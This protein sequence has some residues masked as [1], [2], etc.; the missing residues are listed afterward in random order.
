M[1]FLFERAYLHGQSYSLYSGDS[2]HPGSFHVGSQGGVLTG[3]SGE[4]KFVANSCPSPLHI[5]FVFGH[6]LNMTGKLGHHLS[7]YSFGFTNAL[8]QP[9]S[10]DVFPEVYR[11]KPKQERHRRNKLSKQDTWS[12][13]KCVK[14]TDT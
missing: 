3:L 13:K 12:T 4:T 1:A 14:V 5:S 6:A 10:L 7:F 11:R 8:L 2:T 9:A